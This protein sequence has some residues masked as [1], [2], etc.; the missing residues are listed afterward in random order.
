MS[1]TH[2]KGLFISHIVIG[3][4][5]IVD[6]MNYADSHQSLKPF[7]TR[8][9][10][11]ILIKGKD[12][13]EAITGNYEITHSSLKNEIEDNENTAGAFYYGYNIENETLYLEYASDKNF[14]FYN[15]NTINAIMNSLQTGNGPLKNFRISKKS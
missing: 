5:G 11:G 9:G 6:N 1:K 8:W 3:F 15:E 4:T 2:L 14:D 7:G 13:I 10:R 12:Y